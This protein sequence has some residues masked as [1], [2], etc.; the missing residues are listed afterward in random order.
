MR[1]LRCRNCGA[2]IKLP[3]FHGP[4]LIECPACN[5]QEIIPA[6]HR[7]P[8][9]L[10]NLA[11]AA[12]KARLHHEPMPEGAFE[13]LR[14]LSPEEF[15]QFC[16][17]LFE[18]EGY[19]V[20]PASQEYDTGRDLELM[21][22]TEVTF[23]ECKCYAEHHKVGHLEVE[24]LLGAMRH[25]NVDKG[26]IVTT[27]SFAEECLEPARKAGIE[28]VDADRLREKIE[29]APGDALRRWWA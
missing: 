24:A 7:L 19:A 9:K 3:D 5:W 13:K 1:E 25:E 6:R 2:I 16:S 15:A 27:S 21:Q 22:G 18:Q 29:S 4:T 14:A 12:Y 28:L 20:T 23:V 26:M 17:E 11:G 8:K 10:D